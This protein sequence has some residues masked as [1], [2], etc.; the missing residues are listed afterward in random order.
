MEP[1]CGED[2]FLFF[3]FS[4][5]LN[6]RGKIPK[7]RTKICKHYL[8]LGPKFQTEREPV[9]GEDLFWST[10]GILFR[11]HLVRSERERCLQQIQ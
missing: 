8:N 10:H 5:H 2:L 9:C 11:T 1:E 6:L 3:F 7:I 4:L